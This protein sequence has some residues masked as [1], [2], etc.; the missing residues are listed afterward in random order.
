MGRGTLRTLTY[1]K[2]GIQSITVME[3]GRSVWTCS[4]D[5]LIV[6]WDVSA[7]VAKGVFDVH[8]YPVVQLLCLQHQLRSSLLSVDVEGHALLWSVDQSVLRSGSEALCRKVEAASAASPSDVEA[9]A[10]HERDE[11]VE[12]TKSLCD[13]LSST[14]KPP[15]KPQPPSCLL[16]SNPDAMFLCDAV[17]CVGE[18]SDVVTSALSRMRQKPQ[19]LRDDLKLIADKAARLAV[20]EDRAKE[21]SK[22]VGRLCE[23]MF[24]VNDKN[25]N[26]IDLLFSRAE[27]VAEMA[28]ERGFVQHPDYQGPNRV[29][30]HKK[31]GNASTVTDDGEKDGA[32]TKVASLEAEVA[33]LRAALNE[34]TKNISDLNS[35]K[36]TAEQQVHAVQ[37]Q[38]EDDT[39]AHQRVLRQGE[40]QLADAKR[41]LAVSQQQCERLR[42][43]LKQLQAETQTLHDENAELQRQ[44]GA[45]GDSQQGSNQVTAPKQPAGENATLPQIQAELDAKN[46]FVQDLLLLVKENTKS[47]D[48]LKQRFAAK[49]AE[50]ATALEERDDL[51]SEVENLQQSAEKLSQQH[52]VLAK[53]VEDYLQWLSSQRGAT[54]D[55]AAAIAQF[56]SVLAKSKAAAVP[57]K[58]QQQQQQPL[59]QK[60]VVV[61]SKEST[62]AAARTF[63]VKSPNASIRTNN[64]GGEAFL[65]ISPLRE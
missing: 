61:D 47:Y 42:E 10:I 21:L 57:A 38:L 59:L 46:K 29:D 40:Q 35:H 27:C 8:R 37:R 18:C 39:A 5:G 51:E 31:D 33:S 3:M 14:S 1:H 53:G 60:S 49:R 24:P 55:R 48:E 50:L 64:K 9:A 34:Q 54:I 20:Y 36:A 23:E 13:A 4:L 6:V 2:K 32:H 17:L 12:Y 19:N 62:P 56:Q 25:Q 41:S 7:E 16:K 58:Q 22:R 26:S 63:V 44:K 15:S 28:L 43:E 11:L 65:S 30:I 45:V 52:E